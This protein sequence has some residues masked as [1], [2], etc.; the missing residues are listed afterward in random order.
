MLQSSN[1]YTYIYTNGHA[2]INAY[3]YGRINSACHP[4]SNTNS[5]G[6]NTINTY[7]NG[8]TRSIR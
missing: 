8:N 6:N 5:N 4:N 7:T 1:T 2:G 3:I